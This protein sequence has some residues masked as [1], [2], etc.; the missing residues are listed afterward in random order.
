MLSRGL[1]RN[2]TGIVILSLHRLTVAVCCNYGAIVSVLKS[3]SCCE[4]FEFTRGKRY[5]MG[6]RIQKIRLLKNWLQK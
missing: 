3:E 1:S 2:T 6:M 4:G 5:I